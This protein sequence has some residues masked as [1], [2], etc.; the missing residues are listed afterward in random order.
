MLTKFDQVVLFL[1]GLPKGMAAKIYTIAK[2]DVDHPSSFLKTGCFD[3]AVVTARAI[4]RT[5]TRRDRFAE[6]RK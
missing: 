5:T 3:K 4:N 6:F 1:Q 2:L